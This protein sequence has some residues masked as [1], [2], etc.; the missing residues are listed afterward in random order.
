MTDHSVSDARPHQPAAARLL[1]AVSTLARLG[2]GAVWLWAGLAKMGDPT[3]AARAVRAYRILPEALVNPFAW[4]LP[5]LEIGIGLL[6]V[7]GV[8]TRLAG[9]VSIGVLAV[10]G[11]AVASAWGRGLAI[12]C[13]CFG[14]GG[15]NPAAGALT[16]LTELGRDAGLMVLAAWLV[17]L[18]RSLFSIGEN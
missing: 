14:G 9:V 3:A 17:V 5:S 1:P 6:L 16:Y 18:P 2:L 15:D 7:L 11:T 10:F 8:G 4:G 12:D 13:G